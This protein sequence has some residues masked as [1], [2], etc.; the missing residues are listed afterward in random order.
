MLQD[1]KKGSAAKSIITIIV[2]VVLAIGLFLFFNRSNNSTEVASD[3]NKASNANTTNVNTSQTTNTSNPQP[4]EN[5]QP[6]P[7]SLK[8][9]V[10][11][12]PQAPTANWDE[13]HNEACEEA[14]I[15]MANAYF[16]N[17]T[18]LPPA[19]VE[20]EISKLTKYQQDTFGY[21]LSITTPEAAKMAQEVYGLKAEM[22]TMSEAV[23]KQALANGKL[24][25][26]PANGQMLG[27]P[28][29]TAPGP[30]YHMLVITGFDGDTF[31]TNDP[32]TK[33]GED[34]KYSYQVLEDAAGNWSHTAYEVNRSDKRVIIV[35]K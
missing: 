31:I 24:V 17:I 35:S 2:L 9:E 16:N 32:G 4:S 23:V 26:L 11:F 7:K 13:L 14:S 1:P 19:T 10:P 33:R 18:S 28:N 12:T 3:S 34:Y 21:Y 22:E 29:F 8:L 15:I 6:I 20:R 5:D 27:N 25:I 30:I